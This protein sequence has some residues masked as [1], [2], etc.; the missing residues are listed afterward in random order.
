MVDFKQ[1]NYESDSMKYNDVVHTLIDQCKKLTLPVINEVLGK[2][3]SGSEDVILVSDDSYFSFPFSLFDLQTKTR[4][5]VKGS[6]SQRYFFE[7]R[8]LKNNCILLDISE[9]TKNLER[10]VCEDNTKSATLNIIVLSSKLLL[11]RGEVQAS[12]TMRV[13]IRTPT[14]NFEHNTP[15]LK[16]TDYTL[17]DLCEKKLFLL[18]PFYI[19]THEANFREI[20]SDSSQ[21][22]MIKAEYKQILDALKTAFSREEITAY[23]RML[24]VQMTWKVVSTIDDS[25]SNI[26]ESIQSVL[27]NAVLE[28]D[29]KDVYEDGR[30]KRN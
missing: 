2:Q 7:Y 24:I 15:L 5:L 19:F 8:G 21:L 27:G 25:Y 3:Y 10:T 4:L 17:Q 16:L 1:A 9:Y 20:N 30:L 22:E 12:D 29:A 11:L 14:E 18:V 6:T 23:T 26:K 13:V 28:Y